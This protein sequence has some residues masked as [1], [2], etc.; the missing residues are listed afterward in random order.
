MNLHEQTKGYLMTRYKSLLM[1]EKHKLLSNLSKNQ[2]VHLIQNTMT[3]RD[4]E[5][6]EV[7]IINPYINAMRVPKGWIYQYYN[8]A[9]EIISAVFVPY[10]GSYI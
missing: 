7:A 10:S 5:L 8:E 6:H 4:L 2:L 3:L 1:A 9:G